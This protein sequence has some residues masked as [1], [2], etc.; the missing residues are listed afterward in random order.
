MFRRVYMSQML[1]KPKRKVNRS[2]RAKKGS[3]GIKVYKNT[4]VYIGKETSGGWSRDGIPAPKQEVVDRIIMRINTDKDIRKIMKHIK[5]ITIK[6]AKTINRAGSWNNIKQWFEFV[7]HANINVDDADEII[8]HEI[9]GHAYWQ[10]AKKWRNVEWTKFNEIANNMPPVND[11]VAKYVD[12]KRDGRTDTIY[13]NEQHS[14]IA[15]L[16]MAGHSYH[17]KKGKVAS[18]EQV[19]EM[20]KVWKEMHY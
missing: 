6:Y 7:D 4:Y 10:W 9:I 14:A 5:G 13:E 18:D 19:A 12:D 8:Y 15:E 1:K 3:H 20:I 16:V 17:T 11:Y 2:K